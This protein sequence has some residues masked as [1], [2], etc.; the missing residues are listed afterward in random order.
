MAE[1]QVKVNVVTGGGSFGHKLFSDAAIEAAKVSQKMG[2]PVKLMWHRADEPRQGRLHPMVTSRIRATMLAGQVL[3]FEQRNTSVV[4][5]F[6]H[7]LGEIITSTIDEAPTEV[8][9]TLG[10]IGLLAD[11]LHAHPGAAATTS[12]SSPSCSTRP[13][14]GSTP[15]ACAT[16]T[17]PTPRWPASW[18]STGSRPSGWARTRSSSGSSTPRDPRSAR[19]WRRS[20]RRA[21]WG[22]TMPAG[23]AQGIAIHKEYKGATACLVE[24]DTRP[25][26]VNRPIRDAVTGPRVTRPP[27]RSTPG[28]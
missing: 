18:S 28:W 15:A 25:E 12:E 16:S 10:G 6:S 22:R 26:T 17:H 23:S 19:R 13:T 14:T 24:I 3:S 11:D 5:D 20:P 21:S 1:D 9:K 7:G 4:T 2:K 8:G 27:S